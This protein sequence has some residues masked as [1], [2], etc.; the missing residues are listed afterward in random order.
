MKLYTRRYFDMPA[1]VPMNRKR[2]ITISI[3]VISVLC[4]Q[5]V[6]VAIEGASMYS[7][8][9]PK[10]YC[11]KLDDNEPIVYGMISG[12]DIQDQTTIELDGVPV[13][14]QIEAENL[15]RVA[16]PLI[17]GSKN[18]VIRN[19]E[20][21]L[22]DQVFTPL[23]PSDWGYFQNGT[24]HI[25]CSSH[26]DIAWMDTPEACRHER[27]HKII[28][29]AL[30][31][32]EAHPDFR[33]E[34][35]QT[36]NLM[37]VIEDCPDQRDR[38]IRASKQGQF[39]WGAT[40]TQ[41][42]EGLESGEQLIRQ[43]YLGRK[44]I[45]DHL[46]EMD[47][48]TAYNIDV[49]GRSL[50]FPQMLHK[51][52]V[53]Y[54]FVSRME[55]GFFRWASP[56]GSGI[57]TYSPGN[58][59][60]A[61]MFYQYFDEDGV[62]ALNKLHPVLKKWQPY[63]R[64]RNLPPHYAVVISNDAG[65]PVY[66]RDV[67]AEWNHIAESTNCGM[68][69]LRHSTADEFF[70]MIDVPDARIESIS[71][72]RPNLWL[73]IH[74][75]GHYEAIKAKKAAAVNLRSAEMFSALA[76]IL[77]EDPSLYP[78]DA[79]HRAWYKSIYP[80]HGWGGKNGAITDEVFRKAL[81]E[82]NDLG[83]KMR[84][85]AL[86]RISEQINADENN[87]IV[88]FNPLS[89][90]RCGIVSIDLPDSFPLPIHVTD[91]AGNAVPTQAIPRDGSFQL[92]FFASDIPS[93]GYKSFFIEENAT[94]DNPAQA[95]EF[96]EPEIKTGGNYCENSYYRVDLG[97][98]GITK[99][100]DKSLKREIIN[101]TRYACGD[102]L[103]LGYDGNGAGEFVRIRAT[104]MHNFEKLSQCD[105]KWACVHSGALETS[106]ECRYS[107]RQCE[108]IQRITI[109]HQSKRIDFEYHIPDWAGEHNRQLRAVFPLTMEG[110]QIAY[111]VPMGVVEVGQDELDRMPGG[112]SWEGTYRQHPKSIHPRE[113]QNFISASNAEFGLTLATD[114][115][116]ADWIDPVRDA[117]DYPVL[118]GV[119]L[120]THKSCH[121]EGNW[122][123]QKGSHTFRMSLY[124]HAPGW[125]EGL[126][127]A[128]E[129]NHPMLS[130]HRA[131]PV[132]GILPQS[133]SFIEKSSPFTQ[134]TALKL[135]DDNDD[136]VVRL[137]DYSRTD[138]NVGLTLFRPLKELRH[139]N[140]IEAPQ[141][142]LPCS[143]NT[144]KLHIGKNAIETYRIQLD[145]E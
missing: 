69:R 34:M 20:E 130:I 17:G 84:D 140:L 16:L 139:T 52:G 30:D 106:F 24:V 26:Q 110:A 45:K 99:L 57:F 68:P 91:E 33:F 88:V 105:S 61:K 77:T 145:K 124:S 144:I 28:L 11:Y 15:T 93:I 114:L 27:I 36:L 62:S 71:G 137:V 18:L 10:P 96:S 125:R 5:F 78:K 51:A 109:H 92:R 138:Q 6:S 50:Q 90:S 56:D 119:L 95:R 133:M 41:P 113:I 131:T 80:D 122:Y 48:H 120:S 53:K 86:S 118:Q 29:P 104:H 94:I 49:P 108:V 102:M 44:W 127:F 81:V 116:V 111:D 46:P 123:E 4:M 55:E 103:C 7:I 82:G 129:R 63:Y 79:L 14:H 128:F 135:A 40:F 76:C 13:D 141:K 134:L 107:L 54:L 25:I 66:Y 75:P 31:L 2:V 136:L 100:Y 3:A 112:W 74:G 101:E 67:V 37:E 132:K 121:G 58:Y 115:A 60:W 85:E 143:G 23:I 42:Y 22:A 83:I 19:D 12:A 97:R 117:V 43:L 32:M 98:G 8:D 73:Y 87:S 35:E 89:W 64:D 39:T 1:H 21:I 70:A 9:Y 72:E 126:P 38:I 59:G 47:A 142:N 65:G